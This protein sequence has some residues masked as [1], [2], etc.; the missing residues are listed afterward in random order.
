MKLLITLSLFVSLLFNS[1]SQNCD[2]VYVTSTGSGVGTMNDPSSLANALAIA[3]SGDVIRIATGAYYIDNSLNLVNGVTLEGGFDSANAWTKTSQ[4]GATSITRT[5]QNPE[6]PTNARR[7]V[8]FYGNGIANFRLQDLTIT[9]V[10]AVIASTSTYAVHLDN[11]SDYTIARCQ[12]LP[13]HAG[14]GL[15]GM[16]GNNGAPGVGGI[17]GSAGDIDNQTGNGGGGLGGSG[18][19]ASNAGFGGACCTIIANNGTNGGAPSGIFGG[20]GGGGASGGGEN[21]NGG[22]GGNGGGTSGIG[23]SHGIQNGCTGSVTCGSSESGKNGNNGSDG[24]AGLDASNGVGTHVGGFWVPGQGLNGLNGAGGS[25][26]G[27]GG[28]GAGQGGVFCVDGKGSGGGGGG[29]GGQAGTSGNGGNGGGSSY[30][31]YLVN[32][33]ANGSII[34]SLSN[35]GSA[36][37]GGMGGAGGT[38]GIGGIGGQGS[39]YSS[40]EVGCGGNGGNGGKGGK[41]GNGGNGSL[42]QS[43]NVFLNS[44]NPL[45]TSDVVFDLAAQPVIQK[46]NV[47]CEG[48][49]IQ[50]ETSSLPL[51]VPGAGVGVA[52]W[53]FDVNSN[54]ANPATGVDNPATTIYTGSG[55]YTVSLGAE[56]Y[57]GF[58]SINPSQTVNAG[59]D[60]QLCNV[61][62][63]TLNGTSSGTNVTWTS[64]GAATLDDATDLSSGVQNLQPGINRFVLSAGGCCG[65]DPDTLVINMT[66]VNNA[67]SQNG[68]TLT[69]SQTGASYQWLN[70]NNN[71]SIVSGATN[72]SYTAV[73]NGNYAVEI[74]YNGCSDTSSC[75]AITTVGVDLADFG[76]TIALFPNPTDGDFSIDLGKKYNAGTVTIYDVYGKSV[77]SIIFKETQQV[78]LK[79]NDARGVYLIVVESENQKAILRLV[80]Q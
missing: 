62:T 46:D 1:F 48:R 74:T 5:S 66:A 9:T 63:T 64:L 34:Q 73:A 38:G 16:P 10:N 17:V 68:I 13:G 77:E 70:C 12:L 31:L 53:D 24:A 30:G 25:G 47:S 22:N 78:D 52:N 54:A 65:A 26:G 39:T 79:I 76:S 19:G 36:G 15:N 61:N 33:G 58:V 69:A 43:I 75:F 49:V 29:G 37:T 71:Y 80:K 56:S 8:A 60:Q 28:G 6:G 23:G 42:G 11:C 41:G 55:R 50:F 21:N 67:V 7:L 59:T 14:I 57:E 44:G 51:G 40:S 20:G 27:G 45:L 35:A 3:S 4:A 2:V 72:Q 32:N 18:G